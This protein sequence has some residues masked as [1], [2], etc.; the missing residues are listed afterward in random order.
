MVEA[1]EMWICQV[2]NCGYIYNPEKGDK[3]GK[4]ERGVSFTDLPEDWKC[5]ICGATKKAFKCLGE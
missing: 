4:I 2:N 5:P 3:K 1:N